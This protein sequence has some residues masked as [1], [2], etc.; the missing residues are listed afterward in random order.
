MDRRKMRKAVELFLEAV[1][2]R[3]PGD[4]LKRTPARVTRAWYDELL[5]GYQC[6]P[7]TLFSP[8]SNS[9]KKASGR[10]K[11]GISDIILAKDIFFCSICVHHLLPFLGR[12]QIAYIP[13][14][15]IIGFS[16]IARVLDAYARRLQIQERLTQQVAETLSGH[17]KP[18]GVA[19]LIEAEHLCMKLRGVR[20]TES[21]ILTTCFT[22]CFKDN[23]KFRHSFMNM[24]FRK[25][26]SSKT[27]VSIT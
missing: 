17:L 18:R 3:F 27:P 23:E 2:E 11:A 6:D 7:A 16:K 25:E 13:D 9:K 21:S 24:V 8:I 12:A 1:N 10:K 5:S 14:G 15:R 19:V 26:S 20:K 4:D 22:G